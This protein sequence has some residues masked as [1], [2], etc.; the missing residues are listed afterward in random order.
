MFFSYLYREAEHPSKS[1]AARHFSAF[2]L[3]TNGNVL[4]AKHYYA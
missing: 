1:D 3:D 4:A 2:E